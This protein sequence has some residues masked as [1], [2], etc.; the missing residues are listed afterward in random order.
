MAGLIDHAATHPDKPALIFGD[1]NAVV[2]YGELE[3]RS[4]RIAHWLRAQGLVEGD[5]IA[6]LVR[7]TPILFDIYWATQRIGLYLTPLNWHSTADE[8]AYIL[9]NCDAR[10]LIAEAALNAL[11]KETQA[12]TDED[13][14]FVSVEGNIAGFIALE[15][16]MAGIPA[17]LGLE[18]QRAGSVMIY[19]SGTTGRPKG[20]RRPLP[21]LSFYDP[22]YVA[23]T[24]LVMQ[25]FGFV[26][27]DI[28][29]CP[30]P[31]YH[32][33]PLRSC[34]AM[35]MMGATV[36]AMHQFD[37][38]TA[39]QIIDERGVTVAQFVPTHF[40]RMLDLPAE[41]QARWRHDNLRIAVHAAAPCP[42]Q[43]KQ[44]MIE[45]WGPIL[46]EYYA[47]TEGG[48]VMINAEDWLRRPGSVGRPWAGL[49][50][51]I[52][53]CDDNM[54]QTPQQEGLIYFRNISGIGLNFSYHK[55][56]EKTA[57]AHHGNWFTLGDIGYLDDAG[58]L[59]LTDRQTNLIIS[60][61]V[62]IYP[63][64]AEDLLVAHPKVHDAAVIGVPDEEMGEAVKAL[65][66]PASN[67]APSPEFANELIEHTRKL[68]ASYKCPRS[69][70]FVDSLPRTDTGKLQKRLLRDQYWQ[71]KESRLA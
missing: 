20:I 16:A 70:D 57:A 14:R 27:D 32:A 8:M 23:S 39:L 46:L 68:L 62:N 71:E 28:Y 9:E 43:I 60:G 3:G 29:L 15:D 55:D 5:C 53:D 40:K 41:E 31:L 52:R 34:S 36:V 44:A 30:A 35:H 7:N 19:S 12:L 38:A 24:T 61:G 22:A 2:T 51:G 18:D 11:A 50:V 21:D 65:V 54:V 45:W 66:V 10:M 42:P 17:D 26:E 48:G 49:D 33:G 6:M 4:R 58:Y 13:P 59:F 69:I 37:A 25:T 1:G 47:G 67:A 64:E 56:P 63:Q